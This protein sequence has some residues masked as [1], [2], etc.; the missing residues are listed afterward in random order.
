MSIYNIG[1]I[2]KELRKNKGFSQKQLAEGICSVEYISKIEHNVK[3]PSP[4]ITSKLFLKLGCN[5]DMFFS[6]LSFIDNE[7]FQA[8]A[9]KLES[10]I[11]ES[12]FREAKSYIKELEKNYPFYASGEPRQ[13]L[14]CMS[15]HIL[16]NLDKKF[17]EAYELGLKS[18]RLTKPVFSI[19]NMTEY[20]FYSINEMWALLYMAAALFWE[21]VDDFGSTD[22]C[23]SIDLARIVFNHL[24]KGY[25]QPSLIGTL[26]SSACFY[27]SKFLR[28][29][30]EYD[31]SLYVANKGMTF[32]VKHYNQIIELFGKLQCN[33][34][35][36]EYIK[37]NA[38]ESKRLINNAE[39]LIRLANNETTIFR[40]LS[41]TVEEELEYWEKLKSSGN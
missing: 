28:I 20:E 19:N 36:C 17:G 8:H 16:S 38:D 10:F 35:L 25:L 5:P 31:E 26:Y 27:L 24:E 33:N 21:A 22:I 34:G 23:A 39:M 13:Y 30:E 4:D 9:F 3:N 1:N 6:H 29:N 40:Y 14:M 15:S 41:N 12:K 11:S 2:I 32:I 37:G 7:A 18:I